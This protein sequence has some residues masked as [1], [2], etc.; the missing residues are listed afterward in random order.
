MAFHTQLTRAGRQFRVLRDRAFFLAPKSH[1]GALQPCADRRALLIF[2]ERFPRL[3]P[4][5]TLG[6]RAPWTVALAENSAICVAAAP[7]ALAR[8]GHLSN[9][10]GNSGTPWHSARQRNCCAQRFKL[11][12]VRIAFDQSACDRRG[13][14][15]NFGGGPPITTLPSACRSVSTPLPRCQEYRGAAAG[16][17]GT[18]STAE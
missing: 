5:L 3:R 14:P 1:D 2:R 15:A 17:G 10:A 4:L 8:S 18:P 7:G 12:S 6:R 13:Y 9:A 16:A 11:V